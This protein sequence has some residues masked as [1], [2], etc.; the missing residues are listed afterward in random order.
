[1]HFLSLYFVLLILL[2]IG[3]NYIRR[4]S[5]IRLHIKRLTFKLSAYSHNLENVAT[6]VHSGRSNPGAKPFPSRDKHI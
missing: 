2:N 3:D 4:T 5:K 1:M 6:I